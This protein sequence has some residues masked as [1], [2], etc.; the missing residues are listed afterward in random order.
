MNRILEVNMKFSN[1]VLI[2][3]LLM[4]GTSFAVAQD[5]S[6]RGWDNRDGYLQTVQYNGGYHGNN[7]NNGDYQR[8][9]QDGINSG[10]ADAN[11]GKRYSLD[12]HPYYT[13]SN[14]QSYR[15]GFSQGYREAYGQDR[16]HNGSNNGY[17]NGQYGNGYP[18]GEYGRGNT[19]NPE[20][21][22]GF[23]DGI[24]SGRADANAGK[25]A[26]AESHP[27]YR[28]S[29]NQTYREGFMQGYREAYGQDR[30]HNGYNHD[31]NPNYN[32]YYTH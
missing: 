8:G 24:N 18:N 26:S 10:R 9:Y 4:L 11:G 15:A 25:R 23:Q 14:N 17:P 20:Y 3:A 12:S 13:N 22:K 30:G 7:N 31:H 2:A 19:N 5:R 16:G 21:Q 27:Y 28:N 6:D 32:P 1:A 29:N